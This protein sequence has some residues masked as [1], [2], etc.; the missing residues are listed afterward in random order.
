M[1]LQFNRVVLILGVFLLLGQ[2]TFAQA[3]QS[4]T[5]SIQECVNYAMEHQNDIKMSRFEEYIAQKKI[6]EI[7]ASAYPQIDGNVTLQ[8]N[9]KRPQFIFSFT[10]GQPAQKVPVGQPWQHV[11]GVTLNQLIFDWRFFI[12]LDATKAYTKL[13]EMNTKR[14]EDEA[15]NEVATAYYAALSAKEGGKLLD[16]NKE[17]LQKLFKD[18]DAMYKNGLVEKMDVDRIRIS[19]NNIETEKV[20]LRRMIDLSVDMLKFQMGMPIDDQLV[21]SEQFPDLEIETENWNNLLNADFSKRREFEIM[22]QQQ[23]L[24][25]YNRKQMMAGY[26]PSI[27]GFGNYQFNMQG[28]KVFTF[29]ETATFSSS[30]AGLRINVPIFD[31]FLKR[32]KIQQSDINVQKISLAKEMLQNGLSLE[33]KNATTI[34]K[35][36]RD[37]Y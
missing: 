26:Y 32:A 17:R 3:P 30:G 5:F 10:P 21:L 14:T 27:Y 1:K 16:I 22:K 9:I 7:M 19:I 36:A 25:G 4:H 35:N 29:T 18:T 34:L 28:D 12:G 11:A 23:L 13:A 31:G 20:K 8:A 6:D 15:I 37:T 33:M 24:E 2:Q